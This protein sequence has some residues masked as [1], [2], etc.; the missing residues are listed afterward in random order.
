VVSLDWAVEAVA[1]DDTS[2][3]REITISPTKQPIALHAG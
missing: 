1:S 2:T 3:R